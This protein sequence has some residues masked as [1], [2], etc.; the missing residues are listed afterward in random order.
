LIAKAAADDA[1]LLWQVAAEFL[2]KLRSWEL[3][4]RLPSGGA[5]AALD[6]ALSAFP[7]CMP[8]PEV[9]SLCRDLYRRHS[10]SHWDS[11]LVAACIEAKVETLYTEDL[12]HGADYDGVK[13]VN[14]FLK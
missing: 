7:L 14:P 2:A 9:L 1:V 3:S 11:L 10:L 13:V 8:S 5:D 6:K 12:A 4:G